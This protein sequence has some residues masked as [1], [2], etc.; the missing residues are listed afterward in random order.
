[1]PE[2]IRWG[3]ISTANIGRRRVVPAMKLA[4]NS[5]VTAVASRD[6]ARAKDFADELDIPTAYGSYEE[7]IAD[8][9]IDA[10]YNPLPNS[11]HAE[12]SIKCA[13]AGKPTLC[14]KPFA[15]D[16]PEAQKMVDAFTS[17]GILFAEA[18]MYRFHPQ[19]VRVKELVESGIL[20]DIR[21]I[22]ASFSFSIQEEDNIRLSKP[23]AGGALM[24][25]GCYCLN[26]MRL[27]TGEEPTGAKAFAKIG[28]HSGVDEV[29]TGVLQF[30][31]G[32]VGHFDCSLRAQH[33]HSYEIRGS[34]GRIE[35]EQGFVMPPDQSTKIRVWENTSP[36]EDRY[37]EIVI[38]PTNHYTIMAEDFADALI[39]NRP[40]RYAPQDGVANM[41]VID[42]LYASLNSN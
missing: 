25:V 2:K 36:G 29:L 40:P 5:V 33:N 34:K 18:F 20:G 3:I 9:N 26:V 11:E 10:I 13:E 39:N 24:D 22:R 15:K 19:T 4:N 17:R 42:M 41:R 8:P 30:P 21:I 14:E 12:W 27:M 16:A 38:P 28:D 6:Y 35:V 37:E 23:L 31:S 1:M 7:L 32:A